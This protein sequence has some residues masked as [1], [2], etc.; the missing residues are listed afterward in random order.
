MNFFLLSLSSRPA[1]ISFTYRYTFLGLGFF[2]VVGMDLFG[3]GC[4]LFFF[5]PFHYRFMDSVWG[6]KEFYWLFFILFYYI[7]FLYLL[8]FSSFPSLLIHI[9]SRSCAGHSYQRIRWI[10]C[11]GNFFILQTNT[12]VVC[13]YV[14]IGEAIGVYAGWVVFFSFFPFNRVYFSFVTGLGLFP[15]SFKRVSTASCIL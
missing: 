12:C 4:L 6:N 1:T 11:V 15:F 13:I 2:M 9:L 10:G 14:S 7:F 8:F 3:I 5:F